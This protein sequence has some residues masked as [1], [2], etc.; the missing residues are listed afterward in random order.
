MKK[1]KKFLLWYLLLNKRFLKKPGM[2]VILIIIPLLVLALNFVS[3]EESG[4]L[5]I[6]LAAENSKD[7]F[8]LQVI[9]DI[10]EDN[11]LI[12]FTVCGTP[13]EAE[14]LVKTN[15][16]DSAWIFPD[17]MGEKLDLLIRDN[18]KTEIIRIVEREESIP[19]MLAR[20][21]LCGAVYK[22][23]SSSLYIKFIRQNVSQLDDTDDAKLLE[24]YNAINANGNLFDFSYANPNHSTKDA[25][26]TGYL[27]T[28]VRG[29]MAVM[30]VL[31]GLAA[32]MFYMQDDA[33][34]TFAWI[35]QKTKPLVAAVFHIIPISLTAATMLISLYFSGLWV[36]LVRE[37]VILLLYTLCTALFCMI[38]RLILGSIKMLSAATP[39]IIMLFAVICPVFIDIKVLRPIQYLFPTFHYLGA[40]H[41]DRYILFMVIYAA[42]CAFVYFIISKILRK[43]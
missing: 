14:N 43:A 6:A 21:K 27:M 26:E 9:D 1:I 7:S 10:T 39:V 35:N 37:V 31:C 11:R 2:W 17:D 40:V 38:I 28:P 15:K 16:A 36:N 24:Y 23:C 12:N 30:L 22:N 34:G 33:M 20:E 8:A 25:T 18:K 4:I 41:N 32:A 13:T 19:L 42:V 29:L 5:R 3:R